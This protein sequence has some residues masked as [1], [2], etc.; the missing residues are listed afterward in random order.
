MLEMALGEIDP[1]NPLF[2]NPN[3]ILPPNLTLFQKSELF[4]VVWASEKV[5]F[6]VIK[7]MNIIF[8]KLIGR[9]CFKVS[10]FSIILGILSL[11]IVNVVFLLEIYSKDT[12]SNSWINIPF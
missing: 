5:I 3:P 7:P 9:F 4:L 2:V 8:F 11:D 1:L 12:E 6:N 10:F